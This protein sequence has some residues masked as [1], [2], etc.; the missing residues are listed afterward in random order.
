[1]ASNV[2]TGTRVGTCVRAGVL[3][4]AFAM[5]SPARAI[6]CDNPDKL[7]KGDPCEIGANLVTS[8]CVVDFGDRAV[9]VNGTLR[10]S[11]NGLIS[12]SGKSIEVRRPIIGRVARVSTAFGARVELHATDD[13]EVKWRI[14]VSGRFKAGSILLDAG[15]DVVLKA[16]LRASTT[17]SGSDAVGGMIEVRA[18][19]RVT[20]QNRARLKARGGRF[21]AGG[22][23][24]IAGAAG[25][26]LRGKVDSV[27]GSGGTILISSE[28][29]D[30][31]TAHRLEAKGRN[32]RGGVVV[33]SSPLAVALNTR[34]IDANGRDAGGLIVITGLVAQTGDILRARGIGVGGVGG[35]ILLFGAANAII[36]NTILADGR[37][38]GT[39]SVFAGTSVQSLGAVLATGKSGDGG[40]ID[41][42]SNDRMTLQSTIS[43]SGRGNGGSIRLAAG[44]LKVDRRGRLLAQGSAG[45]MVA[46]TATSARVE[47]GADIHADGEIASGSIRIDTGG[48]L[49]LRGEFQARGGG[50]IE[51]RAGGGSI[52]ADGD[53][54][55]GAKGCIAIDAGGSIDISDASFD[56]AVQDSCS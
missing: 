18:G 50:T 3:V 56:V 9:V 31:V 29:G 25:V 44:S 51:A 14:D 27:G 7:C 19:G 41:F 30:V 52:V 22:R 24:E 45:G 49:V 35:T 21:T 10:T 11:N 6:L 46:I 16:P 13:I 12:L 15:G 43:T 38:G 37:K 42:V 5:A 36:G 33:L 39:V 2:V 54:D 40:S 55:T 28:A 47:A 32:G 26:T 8:P 53:F 1:M 17:S 34:R 20:S 48:D 23:V 4:L